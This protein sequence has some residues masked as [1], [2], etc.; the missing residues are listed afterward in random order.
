MADTPVAIM[1]CCNISKKL[2]IF[3]HGFIEITIVQN[4]AALHRSLR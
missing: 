4:E 2:R 1:I 3:G